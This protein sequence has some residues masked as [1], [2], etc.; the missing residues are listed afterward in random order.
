VAGEV[1]AQSR[2]VVAPQES[3]AVMCEHKF[4]NGRRCGCWAQNDSVY[5][6]QHDPRKKKERKRAA[7]KRVETMKIKRAMKK[8][9]P[10]PMR[11][12]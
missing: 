1:V 6:W 11:W 4:E 8:Q 3:E 9:I 5:C 12:K 10:L 2:V 7:R